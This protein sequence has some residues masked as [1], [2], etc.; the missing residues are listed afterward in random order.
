MTQVTVVIEYD[1]DDYPEGVDFGY[2]MTTEDLPDG[3]IIV[4][5]FGNALEGIEV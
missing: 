3:N 2:G 4:V 5:Y 1:E